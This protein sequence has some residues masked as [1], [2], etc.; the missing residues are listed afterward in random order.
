LAREERCELIPFMTPSKVIVKNEK[1]AAI[2]FYR[3]E[4]DENG[5]WIVDEDQLIRLKA[6]FV[7]SAFGS[8]LYDNDGNFEILKIDFISWILLG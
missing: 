8:G 2:E 1:I 7:I 6:N 5:K 4:Q 3:T